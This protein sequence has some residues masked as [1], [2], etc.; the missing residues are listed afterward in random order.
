MYF[1]NTEHK[2]NY[3]YLMGLYRLEPGENAEYEA[4]I[5]IAAY[6]SVFD[7]YNKEN[8]STEFGPL[9]FLNDEELA[10]EYGHNFGALTGTTRR[11]VAFGMSLY[12]GFPVSLSDV[13]ASL[14]EEEFNV[15]IQ[16]IKI[17][18]RK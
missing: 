13:F 11:L 3:D 8:I 7:C 17:R 16:A 1:A 6:P 15:L 14:E 18:A 5:Y 4:S 9:V 2:E 10:E 12:N